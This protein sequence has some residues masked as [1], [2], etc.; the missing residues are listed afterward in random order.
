MHVIRALAHVHRGKALRYSLEEAPS[1]QL[2]KPSLDTR[3]KDGGV[4]GLQTS[5]LQ[6]R[7]SELLTNGLLSSDV[8]I[9]IVEF[10]QYNRTL[11][12]LNCLL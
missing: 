1:E 11:S 6:R 10:N 9:E 7:A 12:R 5:Q 2:G 3:V 4:A 8:S